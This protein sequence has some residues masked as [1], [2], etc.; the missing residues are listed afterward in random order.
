M[1]GR[2]Q[3][4]LSDPISGHESPAKPPGRSSLQHSWNG[5]GSAQAKGAESRLPQA[6]KTA[7]AATLSQAAARLVL[8]AIGWRLQG[9]IYAREG[10]IQRQQRQRPQPQKQPVP[11]ISPCCDV[12][13]GL[14]SK[15][16]HLAPGDLVPP[17]GPANAQRGATRNTLVV[18]SPR[19]PAPFPIYLI[20]S[21]G[22][23]SRCGALP[24]RSS[25]AQKPSCAAANVDQPPHDAPSTYLTI[26]LAAS[27][28]AKGLALS[29]SP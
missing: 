16:L 14:A 13:Q 29:S 17:R 26:A 8:T 24:K 25:C 4:W 19:R 7:G 5:R 28:E 11:G 1:G 23:P 18:G 6:S 22:S 3:L 12:Q 10:R 21:P 20:S 9:E 15:G 27:Q 2:Y